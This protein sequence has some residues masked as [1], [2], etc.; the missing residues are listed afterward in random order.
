MVFKK[1][2]IP[3]NKGKK[4]LQVAWNRGLTKETDE[5]IKKIS[6]KRLNTLRK[7]PVILKEMGKKESKTKKRLFKEG[8][9]TAH[10]KGKVGWTNSGS[11]KKGKVHPNWKGNKVG[12]ISLHEWIRKRKGNA[13]KCV[14]NPSHKSKRFEWANISGKYKRN[15]NDYIELCPSCHRKF[16]LGKINLETIKNAQ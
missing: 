8:K 12:Y 5:R 10:N 6:L 16:D 13:K 14:L 3:Y 1:G 2:H 4:R 7:N 9:L 15:V 11:F